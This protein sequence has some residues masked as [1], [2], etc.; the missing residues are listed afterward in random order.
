MGTRG[1]ILIVAA[2][3]ATLL[4]PVTAEAAPVARLWGDDR[5]ETAAAISEASWPDGAE[6]AF[7]TTGESFPDALAA[8]PVAAGL[9]PVLLVRHKVIPGATVR[10]LRRLQPEFI[11]VVGGPAAVRD[12]VVDALED[13]ATDGALPVGGADR[14]ETAAF[15][16]ELVFE[17][18][19]ETAFLTTGEGFADALSASALAGAFG[20][21]LLLTRR[22]SLPGSTRAEIERLGATSVEVI[23]G[24]DAIDPAIVSELAAMGVTV[25]RIAGADRYG[26]SAAVSRSL[27]SFSNSAFVATGTDFP[28]ALAGAAFAGLH[29]EPLL[30]VRPDAIPVEVGCE[31]ARLQPGEIFVLGGP[32]AVRDDV[33]AQL[34]SGAYVADPT[35]CPPAP[36]E[37]PTRVQ[38]PDDALLGDAVITDDDVAYVA[39]AGRGRLEVID[40]R[41]GIR[42]GSIP[43]GSEPWD[44]D[45]APDGTLFV[46]D[47]TTDVIS[48]VDPDAGEVVRTM[49]LGLGEQHLARIAVTD[50]GR[51]LVSTRYDAPGAAPSH[52]YIV[53]LATGDLDELAEVAPDT[54]IERSRDRSRIYAGETVPE[55]GRLLLWEPATE[56]AAVT[57][58]ATGMSIATLAVD[59]DGDRVLVNGVTL[60]D[61]RFKPIGSLPESGTVYGSD[62]SGDGAVAFRQ[63]SLAVDAVDVAT[64]TSV[65][66][67]GYSEDF[68]VA[69]LGEV[70]AA[71]DEGALLVDFEDSVLLWVDEDGSLA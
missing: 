71:P 21:P 64:G 8:G 70:T 31:L 67:L 53:D 24:P 57:S 43:V 29:A 22:Q 18:G 48:V 7:V 39:N 44:V 40:A 34:E 32:A 33:A 27:H 20:E 12:D 37:I 15:L 1:R 69:G 14:Y 55:D 61:D 30:L 4:V 65:E 26:T 23:G 6:F 19:A 36:S 50:D 25:R 16:S 47:R 52:L 62:L 28:D 5:Y 17:E 60:Y 42:R 56:P 10:E 51:A 66:L 3:I 49:D 63:S 46:T 58:R 41:T 13:F 68:V 9:G 45:V 38:L 59:A 54:I 11:L 2:V 35:A